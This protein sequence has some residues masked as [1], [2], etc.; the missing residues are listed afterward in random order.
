[1]ESTRIVLSLQSGEAV[2]VGRFQGIIR[3]EKPDDSIF[4]ERRD[5]D[6]SKLF[7]AEVHQRHGA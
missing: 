2:D 6:P 7:F 1:V 5:F 3:S 4:L